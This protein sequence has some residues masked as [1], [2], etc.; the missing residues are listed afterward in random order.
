MFFRI[1][2]CAS[3]RSSLLGVIDGFDARRFEAASWQRPVTF[4]GRERMSRITIDNV[5][6]AIRKALAD[7]IYL[8]QPHLLASC[9]VQSRLGVDPSAVWHAPQFSA[10]YP[11]LLIV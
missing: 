7:E 11:L 2:H 5:T 1:G 10:L 8:R 6:A 4:T 3:D 9:L